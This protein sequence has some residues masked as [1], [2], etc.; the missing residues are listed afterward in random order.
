[1]KKLFKSLTILMAGVIF[2]GSLFS[3]SEKEAGVNR[4]TTVEG[5][6]LNYPEETALF[7]Y[8]AF[9]L[10]QNNEQLDV[11]VAD[12]GYY[13]II[14]E[15]DSPLKGFFSLGKEPVNMKYEIETVDAN[16]PGPSDE[17]LVTL[18]ENLQ[19]TLPLIKPV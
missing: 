9:K 2:L 6:I 17:K 3:C 8:E 18:L 10:F 4:R 15:T 13:K 5:K 12:D 11:D 16:A 7:Q 1:M 14:L 19:Y